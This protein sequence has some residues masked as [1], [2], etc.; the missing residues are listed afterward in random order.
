MRLDFSR[1]G[2]LVGNCVC[3]AFNGSLRREYLSMHWF[4]DL[5]EAQQVRTA[6]Q[7]DYKQPST[8]YQLAG[9]SPDRVQEGRIISSTV[10]ASPN[11][12]FRVDLIRGEA[13]GVA[14]SYCDPTVVS[15]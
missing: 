11:L 1:P 7:E 8:P 10:A 14:Q 15:P 5:A 6:W 12:T 2:K 3:E 9:P 4:V 13:P